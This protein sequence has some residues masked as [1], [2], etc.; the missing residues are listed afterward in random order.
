MRQVAYVVNDIRRAM[1]HWIE[2]CRI[3]PWFYEAELR[4]D[5]F[6]YRG[7]PGHLELAVAL[8]NSGEMQLE[9]IQ[10]ISPGPSMFH[11][12]LE[13]GGE[14]MHHWCAWPKDFDHYLAAAANAGLTVGQLGDSPRGRWAYFVNEAHPG[15]LIE[16]S[17]ASPTRRAINDAVRQAA[18]DWDGRDPIR[19]GFPRPGK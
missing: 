9:L 2:V 14:G 7:Q 1:R 11:D 18:V 12:F 10:P 16:V 19:T 5:G 17:E 15:S 8:A 3:G 6:T 13:S 4:Y